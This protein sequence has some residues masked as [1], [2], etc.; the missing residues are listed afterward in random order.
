MQNSPRD[1][2]RPWHQ[3]VSS[4]RKYFTVYNKLSCIWFH[5]GFISTL[6]RRKYYYPHSGSLWYCFR[7][8][9]V[10]Y[11]REWDKLLTPCRLL[12][13]CGG[14]IISLSIAEMESEFKRPPYHCQCSW[15]PFQKAKVVKQILQDPRLKGLHGAEPQNLSWEL[16]HSHCMH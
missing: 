9:L 5:L 3:R 2:R 6:W 16:K 12:C 4:M 14:N 1:L 8:F 13:L 10:F 11:I 7:V 15:S